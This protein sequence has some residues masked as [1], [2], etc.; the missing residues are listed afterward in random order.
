ML[1]LAKRWR[2]HRTTVAEHLHRAGVPVRQ[3]GMPAE[4]LYE[5]VRLYAEG[6]SCQRAASYLG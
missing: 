5:A 2:L 3:H 4:M 6:R 1:T